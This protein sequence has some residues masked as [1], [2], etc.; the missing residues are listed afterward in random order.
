MK[1]TYFETGQ[2]VKVIKNG[3][4]ASDFTMKLNINPLGV[5]SI[6]NWECI[7]FTICGQFEKMKFDHDK[8]IYG[9][10]PLAI[11]NKIIGFVYNT[12]L[13]LITE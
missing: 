10:Y 12:A 9:A 11:D 4:N 1:L 13:Q 7:E 3:F 5:Y 6:K 2:K 8:K